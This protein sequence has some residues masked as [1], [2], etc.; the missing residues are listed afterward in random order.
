MPAKSRGPQP[1]ELWAYSY[2]VALPTEDGQLLSIQEL[3]DREHSEAR[4][5][6]RTWAGRVVVGPQVTRI[7]VV[8][9]SPA[10]DRAIN[11]RLAERLT[12]LKASF[13]V[14]EP[15]LVVDEIAGHPEN[16]RPH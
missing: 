3:L 2:D 13:V 11:R 4:E 9:D 5:G 12:A 7:L 1:K 6:A 15:L 10:R 14:T 16:G 8:S